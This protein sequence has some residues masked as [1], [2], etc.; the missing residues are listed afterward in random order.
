LS[1]NVDEEPWKTLMGRVIN[2]ALHWDQPG[3]PP[4]DPGEIAALA[5]VVATLRDQRD[6]ART[7]LVRYCAGEPPKVEFSQ[8]DREQA[9]KL[10]DSPKPHRISNQLLQKCLDALESVERHRA[11]LLSLT[12]T[13]MEEQ[14][15]GPARIPQEILPKPKRGGHTA[16]LVGFISVEGEFVGTGIFSDQNPTSNHFSFVLAEA[17]GETYQQARDFMVEATNKFPKRM[18]W[19]K[20]EK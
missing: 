14:Q 10:A 3:I 2:Q 6:E 4:L 5:A 13:M 17:G 18:Q 8:E 12:N 7:Q 20:P 16:Y 15:G 19:A 1:V 9:R 11:Q